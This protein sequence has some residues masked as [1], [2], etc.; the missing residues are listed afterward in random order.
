MTEEQKQDSPNFG[1]V[2]G[3]W[4]GCSFD[5]EAI[6][7]KNKARLDKRR[8]AIISMEI[9]CLTEVFNWFLSPDKPIQIPYVKLGLPPDCK[10][11]KAACNW[12]R[13]CIDLMIQHES[14]A[15][16]PEASVIPR[17]GESFHVRNLSRSDLTKER[18]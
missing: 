17:L 13:D 3:K 18:I 10:V 9:R 7:A 14:F 12:E 16:I 5:L 15:I 4:I 8:L 11:V 2:D 6:E 1:N